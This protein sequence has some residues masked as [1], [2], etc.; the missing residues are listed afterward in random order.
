MVETD[1]V[2]CHEELIFIH[3]TDKLSSSRLKR[4]VPGISPQ[5]AGIDPQSVL[6]GLMLE[7]WH[8]H[9]VYANYFGIPS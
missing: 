3:K 7:K 5:R 1:F 9:R 2:L 4:L 6:V 8:Q